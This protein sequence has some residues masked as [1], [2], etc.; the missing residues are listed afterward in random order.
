MSSQRKCL[1][2]AAPLLAVVV[3]WAG[4]SVAKR[5]HVLPTHNEIAGPA[6]VKA[7]AEGLPGT[8]V[9]PHLECRIT[10]GK[11][12]LWCATFQIAWNELYDLLGGPIQWN[13][14]PEMVD[15]LNKRPVTRRDLDETSY[16]VMAGY[17]PAD[18]NDI[19]QKIS[20]E[21]GRKFKGT[22]NPELLCLLDP[23]PPGLWATYAYLF[24]EL[25]FE[26]AFK[27]MGKGLLFAGREV[28]KFGI[29]QFLKQ[30]KDEVRAASQVLVYNQRSKD[31]S[32]LELKTQ[33]KSDRLI[34]AKIPP[35]RTLA[36]TVVH[37]HDRLAQSTPDSMQEDSD[38]FIP[39]IDFDVLCDYRNSLGGRFAIT[40]QQTRFR[41]DERRAV[42]KSEAVAAAARVDT[43]LVF[44]KPFLVMIQRTD[45]AQPYF[46]LWVANAELLVPFHETSSKTSSSVK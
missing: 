41:L 7:N 29:W 10:P 46:A 5:T 39:V 4:Y 45:A 26:W 1:L 21:L 23:L 33:S 30:Q 34:L 28:E 18:S 22:A 2:I 31:D 9:T 17:T 11:N 19:R 20:G 14:A 16:V 35:S 40:A 12:V 36:E 24:K 38:L 13:G 37:V 25:P 42:L 15:I 32:I 6:V 3:V 27:R 8:V 44:D 43:N